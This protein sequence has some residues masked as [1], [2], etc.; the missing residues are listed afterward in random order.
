[1]KRVLKIIATVLIPVYMIVF[2]LFIMPKTHSQE[3]PKTNTEIAQLWHV[4][5]FEG[6]SGSRADF[7]MKRAVEYEKQFAGKYVLVKSLTYEQLLN[8][9]AEGRGA[10]IYSFGAG[11]AIELLP[12]L[13]AFSGNIAV[14]DNLLQSGVAEDKVF[15]VPWCAGAYVIAGISE[16][17]PQGE[18]FSKLLFTSARKKGKIQLKSFVTGYAPFNNPLLAAFAADDSLRLSQDSFDENL[19]LSQKDAFSK[20][21]SKNHSVFLLGT[22]RD[23][24]RISQRADAADFSVQPLGGFTDLICYL[25]VSKDT[26]CLSLC[27]GFIEFVLSPKSQYKLSS[28]N[29]FSVNTVGLYQDGIMRE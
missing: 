7:L 26:K 15:G 8:N 28:I 20:F 4:D 23:A 18:N 22:Q 16:L 21:A 24:V 25:G 1:M 13:R 14:Y 2:L 9:L 19:E 12:R 3:I 29:M 17:V 11:L 10:D 6:G 27:T 5:L